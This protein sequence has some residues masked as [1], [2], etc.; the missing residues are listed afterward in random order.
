MHQSQV[1]E[2]FEDGVAWLVDG[3]DDGGTFPGHAAKTSKGL[4]NN[5]KAEGLLKPEAPCLNLPASVAL[6]SVT[7]VEKVVI[8]LIVK[9]LH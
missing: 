8:V 5:L 3:E 6:S 9:I 1:V 7:D 2:E 4:V